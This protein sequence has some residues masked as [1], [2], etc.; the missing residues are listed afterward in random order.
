MAPNVRGRLADRDL[1]LDDIR[2]ELQHTLGAPNQPLIKLRRVSTRSLVNLALLAFAAYALIGIF[3]DMNLAAFIDALGEANWWWLGLALILAQTPRIP[4]AIST[5][6]A[7]ERPLPFGP[8]F[9]LQFAICYVNLAIPSSAARV[10]V[11]V[12]FFQRFGVKPTAAMSAGVIDSVSG[13]IVQI[14]L[15]VLLFFNSNLDLS[16]STNTGDMSGLATLALITV[17]VIILAVAITLL[18]PSL[19][20]RVLT[21]L[22]EA[23]DSLNVLRSSRKLLQLFGG[24]LASQVLFAVA[25]STCVRAFGESVPLSEV[26]LISIV[27][28]LFAGLLPIPGGIGVSEAGFTLGLTA[29]GVPVE[30]AFA[31]ALAYRM[32]SF[33]LPPI[34]GWFCYRWLEKQRYL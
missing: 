27:V 17:I 1:D 7:I 33:Y 21:V 20:R 30:T 22:H 23:R 25:C 4:A 31:I 19:R 18:V 28:S 16:L 8:L 32:V 10:A 24:N 15:F 34:W 9:A 5:M 6:G 26:L 14:V 29:A 12:R 3:G 13:F 11:N 2:D